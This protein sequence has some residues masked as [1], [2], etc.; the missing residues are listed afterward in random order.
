MPLKKDLFVKYVIDKQFV[1]HI[2]TKSFVTKSLLNMHTVTHALGGRCNCGI[3]QESLSR[4]NLLCKLPK[5]FHSGIKRYVCNIYHKIFRSFNGFMVLIIICKVKIEFW[6]M[7]KT[8]FGDWSI[9]EKHL[10]FPGHTYCHRYKKSFS[11]S[12]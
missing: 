12:S 4:T 5:I 11:D 1:C 6:Q 10:C 7:C 9:S 3:C 2:C 8:A